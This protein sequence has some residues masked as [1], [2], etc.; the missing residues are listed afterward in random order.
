LK[1]NKLLSYGKWLLITFFAFLICFEIT[2]DIIQHHISAASERRLIL[3][4]VLITIILYKNKCTWLMALLICMFGMYNIMIIG[5]YVPSPTGMEFTQSIIR[6]FE[7]KINSL[8][9]RIIDTFPLLFYFVSFLAF[10]TPAVRKW[11]GFTSF[12]GK[13]QDSYLK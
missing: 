3:L 4:L 5:T 11:Y 1:T 12:K 9:F 10:A 6:I 8:P 13:S 2:N 7:P